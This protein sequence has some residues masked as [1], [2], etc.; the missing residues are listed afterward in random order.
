[1]K[2]KQ[3]T[4]YVVNKD[5]YQSSYEWKYSYD[6][7]RYIKDFI[8]VYKIHK[9]NSKTS[10]SKYLLRAKPL[11]YKQVYNMLKRLDNVIGKLPY[12][13]NSLYNIYLRRHYVRHWNPKKNM[14]NERALTTAEYKE[15]LKEKKDA[16]YQTQMKK[17]ILN[18]LTNTERYFAMKL[19][20]EIDGS[21]PSVIRKKIDDVKNLNPDYAD[22][23]I[24]YEKMLE[25]GGDWKKLKDMFDDDNINTGYLSLD[26]D[27]D[28]INLI[29]AERDIKDLDEEAITV[30]I[31]AEK[32]T[33]KKKEED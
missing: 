15:S 17:E 27:D 19:G 13:R 21:L 23:V 1:M 9:I 6:Y 4:S 30:L 12:P 5:D 20:Y 31:L 8:T 26:E 28:L 7:T 29:S 10:T 33:A 14:L 16:A 32:F 2:K 3:P 24:M 25:I 11:R 22:A 18:P